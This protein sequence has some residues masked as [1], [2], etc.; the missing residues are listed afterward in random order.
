MGFLYVECVTFI[1]KYLCICAL[2]NGYKFGYHKLGTKKW[3]Q[4][5]VHA[6]YTSEGSET[7]AMVSNLLPGITVHG[8]KESK[9]QNRRAAGIWV[10][11][12]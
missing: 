1:N 5:I 3:V 9:R 10:T 12:C 8:R 7:P 2:K 11:S 4:F 6:T